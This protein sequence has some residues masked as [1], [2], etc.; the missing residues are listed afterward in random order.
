MEMLEQIFSIRGLWVFL[1]KYGI[2]NFFSREITLLSVLLD[3]QCS[4]IKTIILSRIVHI[5]TTKAAVDEMKTI[6][7]PR[8][9]AGDNK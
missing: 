7:V 5:N 1:C 4:H 2:H 6:N 8:I 3:V 9:I